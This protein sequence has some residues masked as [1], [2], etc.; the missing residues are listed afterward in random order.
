MQ[1]SARQ[2]SVSGGS[3]RVFTGTVDGSPKIS[4]LASTS[5]SLSGTDYNDVVITK[6]GDGLSFVLADRLRRISHGDRP[7]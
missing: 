4:D 7:E 2:A 6:S 3:V 1:V 5:G